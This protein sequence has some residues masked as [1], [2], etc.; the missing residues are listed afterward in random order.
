MYNLTP[1]LENEQIIHIL[2]YFF[3]F[4]TSYILLLLLLLLLKLLFFTFLLD[5]NLQTKEQREYKI[6]KYEK[7][8][9][10]IN[11]LKKMTKSS[12]LKKI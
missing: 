8:N 2:E 4:V 5:K 6:R 11:N 7:A 3:Y 12:V 1:S 9:R 10:Y